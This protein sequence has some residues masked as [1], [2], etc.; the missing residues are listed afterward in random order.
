MLKIRPFQT[1][2][3]LA[4]DPPQNASATWLPYAL[5]DQVLAV[6]REQSDLSARA[7][8]LQ[9]DLETE[10]SNHVRRMQK[11]GRLGA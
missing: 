9:G 8:T 7:R 5:L 2:S 1:E 6:T 3:Q 10:I 11:L 4:R